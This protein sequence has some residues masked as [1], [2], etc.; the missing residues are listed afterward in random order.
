MYAALYTRK[1]SFCKNVKFGSVAL[2]FHYASCFN[3][4]LLTYHAVSLFSITLWK[5]LYRPGHA[6]I[7][8]F[9]PKTVLRLKKTN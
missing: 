7:K 2:A 6:S 5:V 1:Q 8:S 9:F 4:S 3:A